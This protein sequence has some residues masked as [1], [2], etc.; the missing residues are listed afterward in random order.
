MKFKSD[1]FSPTSIHVILHF[2][3][4]R[5]RQKNGETPKVSPM[6]ILISGWRAPVMKFKFDEFS[7]TSIP[8][9]LFCFVELFYLVAFENTI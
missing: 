2:A 3:P 1:E 9:T 5:E 8:A 7:P 6:V 4:R